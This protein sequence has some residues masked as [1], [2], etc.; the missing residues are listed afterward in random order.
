MKTELRL[1]QHLA[2]P[3]VTVTEIWCNGAIIGTIYPRADGPGVTVLS[4]HPITAVHNGF[5]PPEEV[6]LHIRTEELK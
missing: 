3:D 6:T 4:K 1:S 5:R 2:R